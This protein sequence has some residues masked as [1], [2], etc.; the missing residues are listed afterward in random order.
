MSERPT[1][2]QLQATAR[3]IRRELLKM[4]HASGSGHS[5]GSLSSADILAC[6]YYHEMNIRPEDPKWEGRD[7]FILSKGHAAPV[8][9]TTLGLKGYFK[10]EEQFGQLRKIGSLLRGHPISN[11]TPGVEVCTG[12]LGQGLSQANGIALSLKLDRSAARVYVVLGDGEC[13]E[14]MIWEAAMTSSHKKL[15]NLCVFVDK[16]ELQID[17]NV[18]DI[19]N[20]DPLDKKFEAFGW[21]VLTIDGHSVKDILNALKEARTIKGKPTCIIAHTVK[22]K[23]VSF[24]EGKYSWHGATPNDEQLAQALEELAEV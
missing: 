23:G 7:R 2:E 17:G 14:G 3:E 24:M 18:K 15:D 6:L 16:N 8:L 12:S 13:Q 5:G 19:K 20:I 9:Y 4:L 10:K 11:V 22:G 21:H 1:I